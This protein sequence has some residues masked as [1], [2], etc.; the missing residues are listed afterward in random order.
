MIKS[1]QIDY[2]V[3]DWLLACVCY[4]SSTTIYS[5]SGRRYFIFPMSYPIRSR[6]PRHIILLFI[7]AIFT[8]SS[9]ISYISVYSTTVLNQPMPL[10]LF[11]YISYTFVSIAY[12]C[13][14]PWLSQLYCSPPGRSLPHASL[15]LTQQ[16]HSKKILQPDNSGVAFCRHWEI[17][18]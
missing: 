9:S 3:S 12:T 7:L 15:K 10:F 2:K 11:F 8:L 6:Y 17:L 16:S 4:F 5:I 18:T 1:F 13:Y 14:S